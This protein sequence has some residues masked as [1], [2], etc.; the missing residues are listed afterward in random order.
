LSCFCAFLSKGIP[1][2]PL[3]K[4][5]GI[6]HVK[7]ILPTFLAGEKKLFENP[8]VP[9]LDCFCC[10]FARFSARGF[11]KFEQKKWAKQI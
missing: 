1:K 5:G 6:V 2:I 4:Q 10:I 8:K 3:K 7:N 11:K 9:Y